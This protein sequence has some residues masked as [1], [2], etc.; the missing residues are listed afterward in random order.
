[1]RIL[2]DTNQDAEKGVALAEAVTGG[3]ARS[4]T[5]LRVVARE[6]E[7][8]AAKRLATL[9]V[10]VNGAPVQARIRVGSL[11]EALVAEAAVGQ[12]ALLVLGKPVAGKLLG[13][14]RRVNLTTLLAE[15]PCAVGIA[16]GVI[17]PLRRI[18]LCEG[19]ETERPLI[20][21][22][23]EQLPDLLQ[24]DHE[25]T[26][27]HVMSQMSVLPS[28]ADW[29][30]AADAEALIGRQTRE[31]VLLERDL[32]SVEQV[33]ARSRPIVRHGLVVDEILSESNSGNYDLLILGAHRPHGWMSRLLSN[34]AEEVIEKA[35]CPVLIV[36]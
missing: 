18:L 14:K 15:A 4:L 27:L 8:A 11:T 9:C 28:Y 36:N 35:E 31:G 1:M 21:R 6:E 2:V 10:S 23:M 22:L 34:I 17:R 33:H 12:Y 19:G 20:E 3:R 30:L 5:L 32:Q 26:I 25:L 29:Q 16:Q 24:P 13:L 7:R